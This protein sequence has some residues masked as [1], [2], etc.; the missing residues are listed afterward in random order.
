MPARS[1]CS[2]VW[3]PPW[4]ARPRAPPP[5]IPLGFRP[6]VAIAALSFAGLQLASFGIDALVGAPG[7]APMVRIMSL[8]LLAQG[9]ARTQE[10]WLG[11]HFMNRTLAIRS[12][13]SAL[14]GGAA[15][16]GLA[17][18][19]YGALG[20]GDAAGAQLSVRRRAALVHV[21]LAPRMGVLPRRGAGDP[22]VSGPPTS[23]GSLIYAVNFSFDTMLIGAFFG[24]SQ[25]G[26][27]NVAKRLRLA[28]QIVAAAPVNGIAMP[29]LAEV[30]N[31][32][33]RFAKVLLTATTVV[34]TVCGPV[35]LGVAVVSRD[36]IV[37]VFGP[38]WAAAA[39]LFQWLAAGGLCLILMDYN[40]NVFLIRGWARWTLLLA[41]LNLALTVLVFL[42]I[43][44]TGV[45][46]VAAPFVLPYVDRD[47][48]FPSSPSCG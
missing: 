29:T 5:N 30:Q 19:G 9:L 14:L 38:Q 35:F 23:G 32:Q 6:T 34:L 1:C 12:L 41:L 31:D 45:D 43:T 8:M 20:L 21:S 37:L 11:R 40:T 17:V 42:G 46:A 36:I 48:P 44:I 26:I 10:V 22:A 47:R 2:T 27:Y 15:G 7:L 18:E 33:A 25:A 39:P 24:P 4:L 13:V 16:V 3:R 28:L